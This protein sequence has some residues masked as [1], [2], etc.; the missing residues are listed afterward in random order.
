M[1]NIITDYSAWSVLFFLFPV[2]PFA[3][4]NLPLFYQIIRIKITYVKLYVYRE[5]IGQN[6]F[7]YLFDSKQF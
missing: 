5:Y 2:F 7:L 1:Q 6:T 3:Y 4:I